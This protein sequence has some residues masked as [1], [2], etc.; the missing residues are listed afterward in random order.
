MKIERF[1]GFVAERIPL[2][3]RLH[4]LYSGV[5]D[6][7]ELPFVDTIGT[8]DTEYH[9]WFYSPYHVSE[10]LKAIKSVVRLALVGYW[11]RMDR[12]D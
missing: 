6:F 5:V 8:W 7:F 4:L 3:N 2:R 10:Q 9:Q 1:D 12:G 11:Y